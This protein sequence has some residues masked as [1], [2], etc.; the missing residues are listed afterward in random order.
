MR[1]NSKGIDQWKG[2]RGSMTYTNSS[3]VSHTHWSPNYSVRKGKIDTITPHVV[4]GH[5]SLKT[6]GRIF[7]NKSAQ[8]SSNYGID[9]DG[10]IGMFVAEQNRSWCSSSPAN[11]HRAVTIEIASDS[12]HPYAITN[13]AKDG[14]I[15]LM[16]DICKRNEIPK[17]LW[18]ADKGLIGKI[19]EQNIT[20]HRW[21]AAKACPGD[22]VFSMLGEIAEEVNKLLTPT[23]IIPPTITPIFTPSFNS[24]LVKVNVDVLNYRI[25]PGIQ[26]KVVGQLRRGEVYTIVA[27]A[28]APGASKWGQLKSGAG[29]LSL[30]HCLKV[31]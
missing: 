2:G 9:D 25:G 16:A 8:A 26:N 14:L 17:M 22:Y 21:F 20:V 10:N 30:D 31:R 19:N 15:A 13:G 11:D 23:Q 18:K 4:V 27:E 5:L 12:S 28:N 24:Y 3:L 7:G 29:W 6:L 1:R